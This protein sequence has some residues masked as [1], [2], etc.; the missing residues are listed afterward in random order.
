[1]SYE[2][3]AYMLLRSCRTSDQQF[4]MLTQPTNGRLPTTE[5]EYRNLFSALRR[6]GHVLEHRQDN[7]ASG[8]RGKGQGHGKGHN[9]Y[10]TNEAHDETP[11]DGYDHTTS[12][13]AWDTSGSASGGW[14]S[15][16]WNSSSSTQPLSTTGWN[17]GDWDENMFPTNETQNQ[18][19]RT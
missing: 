10:L 1:M 4:V 5:Q 7:I 3:I 19:N 18:M 8:I 13:P 17:L 2:G 14:D 16:G 9:G 11:D 12:Y 6:L 15:S